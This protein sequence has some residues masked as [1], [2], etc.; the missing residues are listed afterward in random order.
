[1]IPLAARFASVAALLTAI[2]IPAGPAH[3]ESANHAKPRPELQAA[4]DEVV[5]SG[6]VWAIA[7]IRDGTSVWRG[8]AGTTEL[9]GRRPV[10]V[11]G[12]FRAGSVTKTFVATVI[13]QL[14]TEGQLKL[15]DSVERWLP[16]LVP[17]GANI[18]VRELLQH[19][20]GLHDYTADLLPDDSAVLKIRSRTFQ[21]I[22]LVR[23]ATAHEPNF[24]P[25]TDQAYS[26]TDY[27]LLGMVIE[28]V[29]GQPYAEQIER[30]ILRPLHLNDT[31]LPGVVPWV[32]GR[33]G[34]VYVP[35]DQSGHARAVDITVMNPSMA[36]AAG[37]MVSTTADLNRFYRALVDGHLLSSAQLQDMTNPRGTGFGLGLEVADL[38]CGRVVG[39]G[40]GGPGFLDLSFITSDGTRQITLAT[41]P[42][43]GDPQPAALAM[44]IGALCPK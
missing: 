12:R 1:L 31:E 9:N 32:T 35:A 22:D 38:P 26:N 18:T 11:N 10:S 27:I 13:L 21:P 40:G 33:H 2:T 8:G 30:R 4:L 3:A 15:T 39:H 16:G 7:E 23:L 41:A 17:N 24:P 29:T 42:W 19:T 37:E 14:A 43:G 36:G 28:K 25:G 5:A 20:S 6:G 44:M 34:H